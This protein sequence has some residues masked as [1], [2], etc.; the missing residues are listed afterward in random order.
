MSV[1]CDMAALDNVCYPS[2][3]ELAYVDVALQ[4]HVGNTA[5]IKFDD[6]EV[7]LVHNVV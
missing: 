3:S 6:L 1:D 5:S 4:G 7:P 2:K